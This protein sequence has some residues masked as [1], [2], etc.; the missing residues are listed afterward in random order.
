MTVNNIFFYKSKTNKIQGSK[1]QCNKRIRR[2]KIQI[3]KNNKCNSELFKTK[4]CD[5][6][7]NISKINTKYIMAV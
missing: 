4:N 2:V 3:Q 7:N 6:S 5:S 1:K